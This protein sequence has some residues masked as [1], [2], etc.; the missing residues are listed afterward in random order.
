MRA[1]T[2]LKAATGL[3]FG[4]VLLAGGWLVWRERWGFSSD[5]VFRVPGEEISRELLP[6]LRGARVVVPDR[7]HRADEA[8]SAAG[9]GSVT[10]RR[11]FLLDT[12]RHG[13]RGAVDVSDVPAGPRVLLVGD[14]IALGWGVSEEHS[15]ARQLSAALGAEVIDA[16]VPGLTAA[17]VVVRARLWAERLHPDRV[18]L[19]MRSR[20]GTDDVAALCAG[21]RGISGVA[22]MF[23][24]AST[25]ALDAAPA[26]PPPDCGAPWLDLTPTFRAALPIPGVILERDGS[27]QVLL[28]LP[29]RE[30]LLRAAG[31]AGDRLADEVIAAFEADPSLREPLFYD[32]VHPDEAGYALY[33]RTAST[34]LST[35]F[36][37]GAPD[38][39]P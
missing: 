17:E 39:S 12:E 22:L 20:A 26:S 31:G 29:G 13:F 21:A 24:P 3:V 30:E 32:G 1:E 14:S 27:A 34:W 19:A 25:F 36:D 28:R 38:H 8:R 33:A 11:S 2:M 37:A 7:P 18:I 6:N 5:A 10:R 9:R 23:H 15:L 16:A 35:T 4:A